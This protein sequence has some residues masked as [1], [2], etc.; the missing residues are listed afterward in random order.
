[1]TSSVYRQP[2][3]P[4]PEAAR[5]DP[6]NHLLARYPMRRLDAEA[7]RDA[8]LAVTGDLDERPGGPYVPTDRNGSGEVVVNE[9]NAG[10]ARRSVYLQ[11]RRTEITS[12][13]EV[14]DAPS[15]VTTCTRRMPST[16]PLQ[17]LSLMNSEFVTGQA[18]KLA[19]R[20]ERACK[21]VAEPSA[22]IDAHISQAFLLAI[23]RA[24]RCKRAHRLT[25]FP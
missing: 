23:G 4:R 8:M 1:M 5:I 13:L 11:Q 17:S 3:T 7:I 9:S 15:I 21:A 6:D 2:S 18:Q 20:L 19:L 10:A 14:F 24:T 25:T 22:Q 16:I 12:F